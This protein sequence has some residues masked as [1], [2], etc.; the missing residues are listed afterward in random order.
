MEWWLAYLATGALV[1]FLGGLLGIG[2]GATIVPVLS[3][4]FH[5][6][7]FEPRYLQHLAVG[8]SLASIAFTSVSSLRA[9][10][11]LGAVNWQVVRRITPGI[12]IGTLGGTYLA[13]LMSSRFLTLFFVVFIA[14][15]AT[16]VLLNI[17]PKPSRQFP[18]AAGMAVAGSVIGATSSLV[19][20]G[21]GALSTSFMLWCNLTLHVAIGTSAAIGFPIAVA[22]ALG[23]YVNGLGAQ[24]LPEWSFGFVYLPALA[25]LVIASMLTAPLGARAAH[26]LPVP[27]LRKIFAFVLYALALRMAWSVFA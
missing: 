9:H 8:T 6:Q 27:T 5:A 10:H 1:G 12:V 23:Y 26:R 25:G 14:Y 17:K 15:L 16:Q 2:G 7:H 22:G 18:G 19:G 24:G 11:A 3:F 21:G 4:V 13:K 20:I